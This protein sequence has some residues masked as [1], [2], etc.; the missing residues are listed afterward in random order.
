MF[1]I[2]F[3]NRNQKFCTIFGLNLISYKILN[4]MLQIE[5]IYLQL[6]LCCKTIFSKNICTLLPKSFPPCFRAPHKNAVES[7]CGWLMQI[8]HSYY[9]KC[10]S[11]A[12][13]CNNIY[14]TII[15]YVTNNRKLLYAQSKPFPSLEKATAIWHF[16]GWMRNGWQS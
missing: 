6:K 12:F 8:E 10:K 16:P 14:V 4:K 3:L 7:E 1:K 5:F 11:F 13:A 15:H 9:I 2:F